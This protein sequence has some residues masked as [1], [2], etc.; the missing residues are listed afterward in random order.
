MPIVAKF[1]IGNVER[2][3]Q[4]VLVEYERYTR[5]TG[6]PA[7]ETLG[8]YITV[9]FTPK[10]E[11]DHILKWMFTHRMEDKTIAYP[12]NL[13]TLK[14]AEVVFYQD[15]FDGQ[16]LFKYKLVD[17]L[18]IYYKE[19]FD[20]QRGMITELT[21]SAAIQYFKNL[22]PL[23]K[24][25]N[26]SWTPRHEYKPQSMEDTRPRM[27]CF[28]TDLEGNTQANP[29][30]GEEIYAVVSTQNLIGQIITIDLSNHTKDFIYNGER[31]E[32]DCIKNFH[33]TANTHKI[34]LKVVAQQE[35]DREILT[36]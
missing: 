5:K 12:Y 14:N 21:L 13:Y 11:E 33:I 27:K 22:P 26:E 19:Y 29:T 36:N 4:H 34:K 35:E 7:T 6:R 18:P 23:I 25:W 15:D 28:Y 2:I 24:S 9:F 20:V 10:G 16:I 8:G 32:D 3:L 17:C 30:T 31:I 1:Y